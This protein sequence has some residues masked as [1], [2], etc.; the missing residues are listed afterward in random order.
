MQEN[1]NEANVVKM[2]GN[3]VKAIAFLTVA[4]ITIAVVFGVMIYFDG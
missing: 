1:L 3:W 4:V 2:R